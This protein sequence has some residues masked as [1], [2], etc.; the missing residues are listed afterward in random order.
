MFGFFFYLFF[1]EGGRWWF[2][3]GGVNICETK[4]ISFS[5]LDCLKFV[6]FF[7]LP[8]LLPEPHPAYTADEQ[9]RLVHSSTQGCCSGFHD[10]VYHDSTK[11]NDP[12]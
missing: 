9:E 8:P 6:G 4:N 2:G 12:L 5:H 3:K 1:L 11:W 10:L 7:F